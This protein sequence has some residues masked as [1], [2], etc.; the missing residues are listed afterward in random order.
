MCD[1]QPETLI[2]RKPVFSS[3]LTAVKMNVVC[4]K[5]SITVFVIEDYF[6]YYNVDLGSVHLANPECRAKKEVI[7][8]VAFY[9][10]RTLKDKYEHCGGKPIEVRVWMWICSWVLCLLCDSYPCFILQSTEIKSQFLVYAC[11]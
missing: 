4:G 11:Y 3:P 9:T 2:S 10:V 6:K 7:A 8:G 5:D 1:V